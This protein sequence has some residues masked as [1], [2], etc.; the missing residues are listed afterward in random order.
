MLLS[1]KNVF[2]SKR[3]NVLNSKNRCM[4]KIFTLIITIMIVTTSNLSAQRNENVYTYNVGNYEV[5]LLSDNQGKGNTGIL[6]GATSDMIKNAIP[7]GT[8]P[9]GMNAFLV[10]TSGKTILV[11]TGLGKNLLENLQSL[12]VSPEQVDVILITHMHGDHIGGMLKEDVVVF[13]KAEVYLPQPEHDYWMSDEAMNKVLESRRGGFMNAR[14]VVEAYQNKLHLFQPAEL[15][16]NTTEIIPDIQG[17]AAYGHTPGHSMFM[18]QSNNE[19]M[20]IWGD[21]THAM[22]IQMPY[23]EVAVTYDVDPKQ[24]VKYRKE[25][26]EYVSINKIPVA[27][28]HI[29]YPGMGT[30]TTNPNGGYTFH[31]FK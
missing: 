29:A 9:N 4:K 26:L 31:P 10:R 17:F 24:A 20:L 1:D 21:L 8:F 14:K 19:K 23:P 18:L 16:Q 11:D 3:N 13:P 6:I 12:G 28:M 22:A 15:G 2:Q 27:G 25:V 5:S 30:L 7:D